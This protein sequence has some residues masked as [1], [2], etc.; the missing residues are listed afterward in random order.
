MEKSI[1]DQFKLIKL[2]NCQDHQINSS[3]TDDLKH[4][5]G[6]LNQET[7]ELTLANENFVTHHNEFGIFLEKLKQDNPLEEF[8]L[9]YVHIT[10][11]EIIILKRFTFYS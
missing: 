7:L 4:F 3:I 2:K 10:G 6:K 8:W 11:V 1:I 9:S 5:H